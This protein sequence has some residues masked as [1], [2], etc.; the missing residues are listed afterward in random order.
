MN[1]RIVQNREQILDLARKYRAKNV[2]IF[3]SQVR[4]DEKEDSDIDLL[5]DFDSPNLID[6]IAFKQDLEDLLQMPVDLLTEASVHPLL[7]DQILQEA[8]PL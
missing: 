8:R 5:V 4:G 7:R 3:G 2:R 1:S 6:H